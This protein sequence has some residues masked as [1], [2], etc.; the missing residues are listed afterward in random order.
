MRYEFGGVYA[1]AFIVNKNHL[2]FYFRKPSG[3][4]MPKLVEELWRAGIQSKRPSDTE[5]TVRVSNTEQAADVLSV[6]LSPASILL[7]AAKPPNVALVVN[8][9]GDWTDEELLAAVMAYRDIQ[10]RERAGELRFKAQVYRELAARFGR[11]DKAFEFRMQNISAVL[12]L[13]GR[14]WI[15][16][17]KP[18]R[19]IGARV[20]SRIEACINKLDSTQAPP[21][22]AFE[23]GVKDRLQRSPGSPPAGQAVPHCV[24]SFLTTFARD[25]SVKAWVLRRA[26]GNCECCKD[27]APF[28]TPDGLPYLEVHHLRTLADG[29]SDQITNAVAL[30]P[31]CH[32]RMHYGIDA[33]TLKLDVYASVAELIRE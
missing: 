30:C 25:G 16:G 28:A 23:I 4:D 33:H 12:S 2:L 17:L 19:H 32:R 7:L 20:A 10:Q 27:P 29:G 11:T 15:S 5:V 24:Q 3:W 1:F 9:D 31:N 18:A 8:H 14:E 26:N 21:R 22:V 13:L 6:A